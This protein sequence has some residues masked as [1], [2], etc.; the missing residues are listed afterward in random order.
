MNQEKISIGN[1]TY[2][3]F[4]EIVRAAKKRKDEWELQMRAEMESFMQERQRA[5]ESHYFDLTIENATA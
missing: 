2:Q 4:V 5:K 3:Q 1:C